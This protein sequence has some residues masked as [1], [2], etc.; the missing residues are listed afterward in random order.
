MRVKGTTYRIGTDEAARLAQLLQAR[1][2]PCQRLQSIFLV[3]RGCS[4]GIVS[5]QR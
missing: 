5:N 1:L 4:F 3:P 2:A